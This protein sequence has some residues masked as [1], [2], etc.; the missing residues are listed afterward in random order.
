M[1]LQIFYIF[2]HKGCWPFGINDTCH[3]KE[4]GSLSFAL[5]SMGAPK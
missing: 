2:K 4:Q 5:K 1:A 3:I